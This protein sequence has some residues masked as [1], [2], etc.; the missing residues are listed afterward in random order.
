MFN[1]KTTIIGTCMACKTRIKC[2]LKGVQREIQEWATNMNPLLSKEAIEICGK[3]DLV[4]IID[5]EPDL[6]KRG[7][8]IVSVA[9]SGFALKEE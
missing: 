5:Q 1:E 7:K 2:E 3:C 4:R 6:E 8:Y 9:K